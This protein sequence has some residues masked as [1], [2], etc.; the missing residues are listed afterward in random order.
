MSNEEAEAMMERF[1]RWDAKQAKHDFISRMERKLS[2]RER[3]GR[4]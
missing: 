2:R 3:R 4:P 1:E